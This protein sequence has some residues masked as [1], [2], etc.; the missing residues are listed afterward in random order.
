MKWGAPALSQTGRMEETEAGVTRASAA[1]VETPTREW[2]APSPKLSTA[3]AG[4]IYGV[5]VTERQNL[6]RKSLT[7]CLAGS[8]S[9]AS[10]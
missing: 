3:A 8:V 7:G 4:V 10:D 9:G 1:P 5:P 2:G 6:S